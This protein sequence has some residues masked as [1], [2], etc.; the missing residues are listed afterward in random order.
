MPY[1]DYLL[2]LINS[3]S[4]VSETVMVLEFAWKPR[5]VVII[6]VNSVER[7]T[8]DISRT[9]VFILPP[10][11]EISS[12]TPSKSPEFMVA[13][14]RLLPTASRP[15]AFAKLATAIWQ[16]SFVSPLS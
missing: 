11:E 8:F 4:S 3:S 15:A 16:R 2:R 1:N 10:L 12:P 7:S 14:K 6:C 5:C 13:A 9:P